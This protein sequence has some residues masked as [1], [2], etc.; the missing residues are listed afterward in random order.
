MKFDFT[1]EMEAIVRS[2]FD[3]LAS[4]PVLIFPTW[5]VANDISRLSLLCYD[6]SHDGLGATLEHDKVL[7]DVCPIACLSRATLDIEKNWTPLE[8]EAS[9]VVWS[10]LLHRYV[11]IS[12]IFTFT[13]TPITRVLNSCPK[14]ANTSHVRNGILDLLKERSLLSQRCR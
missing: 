7:G 8:L 12:S 3:E 2:M 4:P 11:G 1:P 10:I 13:T 14:S 6:G 5:D 9:A